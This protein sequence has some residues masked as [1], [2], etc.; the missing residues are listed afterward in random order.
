[1]E[2]DDVIRT[3]RSV[4]QYSDADIDDETLYDL[5][6]DVRHAPSSFNLQPWEFL[7]VRGDDLERLQSV[8]YGQEHVTDAAAAVVV[9]GT[10][11][12][13]DHAERVTSDLLEKGYLPNEEAAEARLDTVEGLSNADSET[14]R[15]WT[16]Q[17]STLAAMTL[18]HAAWGRGIA[19]CPM[20]G[21]DADA[22]REEF[23]V[24][25]DYE[26]VMV[27]T[28]GYP[29]D[30]AADLERPRKFRRPTEEF[31]HLDEFD[32]VARESPATADD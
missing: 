11:D 25:D 3:R 1:M 12:P 17:S 18:M 28:L 8:A 21:F 7:V 10:L 9:L 26:A 13:S 30:E 16:T 20:G 4:H 24:P 27:V 23:D 22:L 6:E 31:L 15:V 19:S 14:R 32:P 2:F 29:E 5:F